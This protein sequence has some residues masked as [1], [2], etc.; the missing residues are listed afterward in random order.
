MSETL[1]AANTPDADASA[2]PGSV[3][4]EQQQPAAMQAVAAQSLAAQSLAAQPAAAQSPAAQ[5]PA[6][7][8][9]A[10]Q[11]APAQSAAALPAADPPDARSTIEA[12][13]FSVGVWNGERFTRRDLHE[14]ARNFR[15]LRGR[16]KPPLKLGHDEEQTLLGQRDGDPALGWVERVWVRGD[17]LLAR[18]AA[19]PRVVLEAIRA[20]R[21]RRVSAELYLDV[22]LA[23]RRL[24]K[25]LKAVA[26]L[27]ADLPAVTNLADLA[28]YLAGATAELPAPAG[29]ARAYS[30]PVHAGRI[31]L[32][33][34]PHPTEEGTMSEAHPLPEERPALHA[35]LAELRAYKDR[36]EAHHAQEQQRRQADAFRSAREGAA[37]FCAAQVQAGRLP[38]HLHERLL[39]ELD[40]QART[41]ADGQPLRV[42]LDWVRRFIEAAPPLLPAGEQAHAAPADPAE[43]EQAAQ[44]PNPSRSLARLAANAMAELNLGYGEAAAYVL[45]THP[46]LARAYRDFTLNPSK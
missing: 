28:V 33:S 23:G 35:E 37:D 41:F 36:Q 34:H 15:R 14:I 31:A 22:R 21:Y 9:P 11:T 16:L 20:G 46:A 2:A 44:D 13:I 40:G 6:A 30:L 19:V 24:G 7:Q 3:P 26:L 10:A 42:S 8:A 5:S 32:H 4:P 17:T 43:L 18:F 45:R 27:G 29:E 12:E 1:S 39:K 38:P 25:A